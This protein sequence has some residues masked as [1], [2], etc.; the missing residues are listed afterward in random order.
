MSIR[1]TYDLEVDDFYLP[2]TI[3][4]NNCRKPFQFGA[5]LEGE[6]DFFYEENSVQEICF[7][8]FPAFNRT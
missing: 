8:H 4:Y 6:S 2:F 3:H 5:V 1:Y 7:Y